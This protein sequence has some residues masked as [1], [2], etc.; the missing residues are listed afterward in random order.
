MNEEEKEAIEYLKRY[1]NTGLWYKQQHYEYIKIVIR[2]VEKLQKENDELK[3]E[4]KEENELNKIIKDTKLDEVFCRRNGKK[5]E[6]AI[7][8][9][10]E[11]LKLPECKLYGIK[12]CKKSVVLITKEEV[13]PVQK[14]KDKISERQFELQQE[15]KD[16]EDDAILIVLQELLEGRK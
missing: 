4:L 1:S 3:E 14:V 15:Y 7:K 10:D 9:S 6:Q 16:F 8:L 11:L 2:L 12:K 5:V 13:I